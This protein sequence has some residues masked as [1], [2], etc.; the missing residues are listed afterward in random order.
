MVGPVRTGPTHFSSELPGRCRRPT[1]YVRRPGLDDE[2]LDES[3]VGSPMLAGSRCVMVMASDTR[4]PG[5]SE[6]T[7]SERIRAEPSARDPHGTVSLTRILSW[8]GA[9][10]T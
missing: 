2:L 7:R 9:T 6:L 8:V 4:S 10:W 5:R 1:F 3:P